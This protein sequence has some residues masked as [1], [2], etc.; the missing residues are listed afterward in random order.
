MEREN[1]DLV[2]NNNEIPDRKELEEKKIFRDVLTNPENLRKFEE[3]K[4]K[5]SPYYVKRFQ[6]LGE[7]MLSN[8]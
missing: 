2:R 7:E 6:I 4:A 3:G 5:K 1:I 8:E